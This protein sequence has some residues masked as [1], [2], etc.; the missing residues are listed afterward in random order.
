MS[1]EFQMIHAVVECIA[2]NQIKS[3]LSVLRLGAAIRLNLQIM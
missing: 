3:C 2:P 1:V